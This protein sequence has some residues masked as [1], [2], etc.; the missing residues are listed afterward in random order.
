[1]DKTSFIVLNSEIKTLNS[2]LSKMKFPTQD[3]PKEIKA[4][5]SIPDLSLVLREKSSSF[6][7]NP[8]EIR[9]PIRKILS[10]QR[11]RKCMMNPGTNYEID[12][13]KKKFNIP[14]PAVSKNRQSGKL[15]YTK[16]KPV[17]NNKAVILPKHVRENPMAE[18]QRITAKEVES[19][20][21]SLIHRGLIPKDVDLTPAFERGLPPLQMKLAKFHDW[22]DMAPPPPQALTSSNFMS[23]EKLSL[24][25]PMPMT[26]QATNCETKALVLAKEEVKTYEQIV[27]SFSSHQIIFR[28]GRLLVTPEY[29]SFKRVHSEQWSIVAQ[30]LAYAEEVFGRL[31]TPLVYI[32][33]KR[34]V[35][36]VKD[37]LKPLKFEDL[38]SCVMN[39]S[40]IMPILS[41]PSNKFRT[42][43]GKDL[44]AVKIQAA[45]KRYK[46]FSAY[47]QL[48]VL[49]KKSVIIQNCLRNWKRKTKTQQL[50]KEKDEVLFGEHRKIQKKF[51]SEYNSYRNSSRIEIHLYNCDEDIQSIISPEVAQSSQINRIFSIKNPLIDVIIITSRILPDEIKNYYYRLL[52]IG[53]MNNPKSRITFIYPD[54]LNKH[55]MAKRASSLLYFSY[56]TL[57]DLKKIIAG[58]K[59]YIVPGKLNIY[60]VKVSVELKIPIL[61]G[62]Y[63]EISRFSM[64]S[65]IKPL[66]Q[67]CDIPIP[68]S[69]VNIT[70]EKQLYQKLALL[71]VQYSE[72]ETWIFKMNKEEGSRGLAFFETGNLRMI[73]EIRKNYDLRQ[74]CELQDLISELKANLGSVIK[75][76]MPTLYK[77]WSHYLSKFTKWSGIIQSA[78]LTNKAYI[79]YPA[80][81]FMIE[82]D[83]QVNYVAS[84]DYLHSTD[85]L[86]AACFFPQTSLSQDDV[87]TMVNS[88]TKVLYSKKLYGHFTL[89]LVAFVDP[90]SDSM[91][92]VPWAVDLGFGMSKLT[93]NYLYFHF[94]ISGS[95]DVTTGKYFMHCIEEEELEENEENTKLGD[96]NIYRL[97]N[98]P[99]KS[100]DTEL[101]VKVPPR[102]NGEN[103][104][105]HDFNLYDTREF[106]LCWEMYHPDIS[107]LDLKTFF[108]MCRYEGISYELEHG[109]GVTFIIYD[110]L[111]YGYVA[112]MCISSKRDTLLKLQND[113]FTFLLNQAGPAPQPSN[114]FMGKESH[115][116]SELISKVRFMEKKSQKTKTK[117][118]TIEDILK[119]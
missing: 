20:I 116:L 12:F 103:P 5:K 15:K 24:P 8:K 115:A 19:G 109:R 59:V 34:L 51:E 30:A 33:G 43:L 53:G 108:H 77:N 86:N 55:N 97:K 44:A 38:L 11:A 96:A 3:A 119:D 72:V 98:S 106:L 42:A 76:A 36:L 2:A 107:K 68:Y 35:G 41:N 49:I 18:P 80:V 94:L 54:I 17:K 1:M 31:A 9:Q 118:R 113:V 16:P 101:F 23:L 110:L 47:Q 105:F 70:S 45:W 22:R 95:M 67:I 10:E 81:A 32:D 117:R 37:E 83:G 90:Y 27:D 66:F 74:A 87:I 84:C 91:K 52:E 39:S 64:K 57:S 85:Y 111:K 65:E 4:P 50:I 100:E 89:Q 60:D 61:S 82:P 73:A 79:T 69:E 63:T 26:Q 78:P 46:A 114:E 6:L 58:K 99:R 88:L 93:A 92:P 48:K 14:P 13:V 62:E 102:Y 7:G 28:K 40:A 25:D 29:Q 21:L 104:L 71:I 75:Y 56:K 112:C